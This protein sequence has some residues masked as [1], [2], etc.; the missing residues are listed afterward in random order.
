MNAAAPAIAAS[1]TLGSWIDPSRTALV[2]VDMQVDFASPEGALG[3][4]GAD[5]GGV[6][7]ALAAASRMAKAARGAGATVVFV[8]LETRAE[9]DSAA[10]A[11][12]IR[13]RGGAPEDV[14]ALCRASTPG[15]KFHGP[16]PVGGD[17]VIAKTR[18]SGFFGTR[19]DAILKAKGIDALVVCG[20]T[21]ECCVDCT[22]RDAF[23]LDY[24]VFLVADACAAYDRAIHEGALKILERNF[25]ILV[26]SDAVVAAWA[27]GWEAS[28]G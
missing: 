12:R 14:A 18:Y 20:V 23:H 26:Q 2:I 24:Q 5:L 10:W 3:L 11:E 19:L 28:R 16:K 9:T 17:L 22:V 25:T 15:A 13:R 4:A 21:T 27:T 6:P 1:E 7:L 8:G